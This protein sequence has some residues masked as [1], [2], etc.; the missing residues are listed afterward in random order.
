ME[1]H[2]LFS[3]PLMLSNLAILELLDN[4]LEGSDARLSGKKRKSPN[5]VRDRGYALREVEAL[6]EDSS[7]KCLCKAAQFLY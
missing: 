6:S 3:R 1:E 4:H 5:R 7:F 2:S